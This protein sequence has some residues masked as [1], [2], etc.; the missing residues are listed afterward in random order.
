VVPLDQD[1]FAALIIALAGHMS[2][3]MMERYS[4]ARN[5]AKRR[6]VEGLFGVEIRGDSP[7][8][9]PQSEQPEISKPM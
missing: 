6:A 3:K 4:H 7:Q 2:R 1:A 5:E 9:P 8:F